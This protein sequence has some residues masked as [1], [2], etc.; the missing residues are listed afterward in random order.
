MFNERQKVPLTDFSLGVF[1]PSN[2]SYSQ[3]FLLHYYFYFQCTVRDDDDDGGVEISSSALNEQDTN[4]GNEFPAFVD[5]DVNLDD[6]PMPNKEHQVKHSGIKFLTWRHLFQLSLVAIYL[7]SRV[8]CGM[9][10]SK[11]Y[12]K[13]WQFQLLLKVLRFVIVP[14]ALH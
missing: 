8:H 14:F 9:F 10:G 11:R 6:S 7:M 3:F 5:K 1:I 12:K 2:S 13:F 4:K